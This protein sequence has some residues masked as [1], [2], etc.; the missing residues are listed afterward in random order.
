MKVGRVLALAKKD[1][2]RIFREPA[3]LFII[4]LF[5]VMLTLAFGTSFGAVGGSQGT[6]FS[7]GVVA[8]GGNSTWA[9]Q[10]F[11]DLKATGVFK[12]SSYPDNGTAQSAL[13]QGQLQAIVL[14]PPGFDATVQSFVAHPEDPA[15]WMN[16]TLVIGSIA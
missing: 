11:H 13:S 7:I 16:S 5:P 6:S 1:W 10:F 8:Q 4:I 3:F 9:S 15:M 14:L 12:V 2:K